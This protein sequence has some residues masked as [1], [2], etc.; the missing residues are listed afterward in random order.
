MVLTRKEQFDANITENTESSADG[1]IEDFSPTGG[2]DENADNFFE[3]DGDGGGTTITG[4]AAPSKSIRVIFVNISAGDLTFLDEDGSSSAENRIA[5]GG[6]TTSIV[7]ETNDV[8]TLIY[9]TTDSR[10]KIISNT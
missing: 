10:W 5:M 1:Y 6:A 8:A 4:L 7:L 2:F 9:S 3:F